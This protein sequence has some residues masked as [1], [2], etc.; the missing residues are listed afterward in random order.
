MPLE[1]LETI[2]ANHFQDTDVT[3]AVYRT[4]LNIDEFIVTGVVPE[5]PLNGDVHPLRTGNGQHF[6]KKH[7]IVI[8]VNQISLTYDE[9]N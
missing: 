9:D 3:A 5:V 2:Q 8:E 4:H 7:A 6:K 1:H